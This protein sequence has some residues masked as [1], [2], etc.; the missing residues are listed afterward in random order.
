M[1]VFGNFFI[2]KTRVKND[3]NFPFSPGF[4]EAGENGRFLG[5]NGGSETLVSDS[6]YFTTPLIFG[7]GFS[8]E[9]HSIM[10]PRPQSV[11]I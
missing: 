4:F 6:W 3:I 9:S 8:P 11:D 7:Q 10:F 5:E 1:A 2:V